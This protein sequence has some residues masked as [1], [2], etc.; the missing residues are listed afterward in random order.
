MGRPPCCD[1]SNVKKGLWTAEE[2]AKILAY[3]AIHGVGNWSLIPKK[4]GLNRCGKSCRLR[5]TNYLRPDLKHDSF[6]PQEEELIIQCH[7]IIGSRWSSIARKLPGR[8]DNDVKNHWNTKLKKRLMKMG[9]DPVTHKP[10]SQL[11]SEFRN[12]NGHGTSSENFVR[13]FKTEPSNNSILTQSNSAWEMFRNTTSHESNYNSPM[14]F[15]NP[16][17]SEFQATT[18]FH[19]SSHSNHLLNGTTSS[20]SSSSS[21]A[22]IT[23]P[24]QGAQAPVTTFCWSDFLLSDPALPLDSQT[25]VVGSSATS[26][27]TFVQNENF[28][29]QGECSSQKIASKASGSCHSASSFVDEILDK[30]QEMLSQFPQLLN[31][32]DY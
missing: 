12:I 10:V 2:D 11:L 3:V 23:Q 28:N 24:N 21:S 31:D 17:S 8:T 22:S 25:Q 26:N 13:D 16:T 6:S 15:T 7:G 5:W 1:K 14:M 19:I 32:F 9:I 18:P 27:L 20:C 29:S 4:A 30:D